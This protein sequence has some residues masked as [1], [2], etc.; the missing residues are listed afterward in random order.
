MARKFYKGGWQQ[1]RAF[2][3]AVVTRGG[4]TIWV[5]GHG[6]PQDTNG[7]PL[8]GD[9]AAQTRQSFDNMAATLEDAGGALKDIVTMTVFIIDSRFGDE[10]IE[11][12]KGYFPDGNFPA[13]AL[14]T[15]AGF[16]K[17][18]MMVEIQAVAVIGEE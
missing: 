16:A 3:P 12:R 17:P 5:A 11:L 10:F 2:S 8:H 6:A 14:I 13:S 18:H 7:K 4:T 15:C 9:F 1:D